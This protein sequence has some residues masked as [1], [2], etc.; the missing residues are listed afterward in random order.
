MEVIWFP[1]NLE[2]WLR[3][4]FN[5]PLV[6]DLFESG[7]SPGGSRVEGYK[8]LILGSV[9][10]RA[11][12]VSH[13]MPILFPYYFHIISILFQYVLFPYCFNSISM[14]FSYYFHTIFIFLMQNMKTIWNKSGKKEKPWISWFAECG[15]IME[16]RNKL[17]K[18]YAT[19]IEKYG[20]HT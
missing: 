10:A 13:I 16:K 14:L 12:Y 19:H 3:H 15:K 17:A 5:M 1:G 2:I 6:E 8:Q 9:S 4:D 11:P 20:I 18:Q 7:T